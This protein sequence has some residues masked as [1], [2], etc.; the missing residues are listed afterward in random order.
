MKSILPSLAVVTLLLSSVAVAESTELDANEL[1][2][3]Y[4]AA[5]LR[6]QEAT[7]VYRSLRR[8]VRSN[9]VLKEMMF[10]SSRATIGLQ[11]GQVP[12]GG[13]GVRVRSVTP[14]SLAEQAGLR[15]EDVIVAVDDER[16]DDLRG[17]LASMQMM[18]RVISRIEVGTPVRIEFL[19]AGEINFTDTRTQSLAEITQLQ[20]NM[21]NDRNSG[22]PTNQRQAV[23]VKRQ[24]SS[25]LNGGA[26]SHWAELTFVNMT[27]EL[28]QYFGAETGV[29]LVHC[30]VVNLPLMEGDVILKIGQQVPAD[31]SQAARLMQAYNP[32]EVVAL[33][34]WRH[35]RSLLLEFAFNTP[36]LPVAQ[37]AR[38]SR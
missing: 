1:L 13:L 28:G 38:D 29:L 32:D 21:L 15:A 16:F 35:G 19:R 7:K 24:R 18:T 6:Y 11:L 9:P 36:P 17:S 10:G 14:G 2:L 25:V 22:N 31:A 37:V 4:Q 8:D 20:D 3:D 34:I 12:E 23:P 27:P 5:E 30:G 26:V 33:Q